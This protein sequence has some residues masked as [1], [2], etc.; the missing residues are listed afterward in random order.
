MSITKII[1]K[2]LLSKQYNKLPKQRVDYLLSSL[3]IASLS[4][5]AFA[6]DKD[7]ASN[8]GVTQYLIDVRSLLK[9]SG[10]VIDNIDNIDNIVLSLASNESGFLVNLGNGYYQYVLADLNNI[11]NGFYQFFSTFI[12]QNV[13]LILKELDT[14]KVIHL[15]ASFDDATPLDVAFNKNSSDFLK[16]SDSF[17]KLI[18][19]NDTNTNDTPNIVDTLSKSWNDFINSEGA[20]KKDT[21]Q[22]I[23]S[24]G[25]IL[26]I[27]KVQIKKTLI[28]I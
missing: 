19:V 15:K 6:K 27:P 26:L 16:Y 3:A 20:D 9:E 1:T 2:F 10:T 4:S 13:S 12:N 25:T 22:D 11:D 28:K 14:N 18:S 24:R 17:P 8:E 7:N 21:N 23:D 5:S